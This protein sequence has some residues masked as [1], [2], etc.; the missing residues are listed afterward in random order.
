MGTNLVLV[1]FAVVVIG[2]HGLDHGLDRHRFR[3]WA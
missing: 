2:G 3:G 1:V